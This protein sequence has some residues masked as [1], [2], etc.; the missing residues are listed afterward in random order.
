MVAFAFYI[1]KKRL[2]NRLL[3]LVMKVTHV[4]L[5]V[6]RLCY[7]SSSMD[8]GVRSKIIKL[9]NGNWELYEMDVNDETEI[10]RFYHITKESNYDHVAAV[11]NHILC[12]CI[13]LFKNRYTCSEWTIKAYNKANG[14]DL[15]PNITLNQLYNYAKLKGTRIK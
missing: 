9:T 7:S 5:V 12:L 13:D 14:T 11:L 15:N 10:L 6:N 2:Y 8:G 1:G 3:S 4:E